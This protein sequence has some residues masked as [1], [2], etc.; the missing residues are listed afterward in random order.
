[1]SAGLQLYDDPPEPSCPSTPGQPHPLPLYL[2]TLEFWRSCMTDL[3][4]QQ[5]DDYEAVRWCPDKTQE[6]FQRSPY[7]IP[8]RPDEP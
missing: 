1:M 7:C 8:V 2:C 4:H 3:D 5:H 6:D